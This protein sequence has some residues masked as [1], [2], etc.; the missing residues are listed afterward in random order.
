[1]D[2]VAVAVVGR[3]F[4][5]PGGAGGPDGREEDAK[6]GDGAVHDVDVRALDVVAV[7]EDE[8][9]LRDVEDDWE[10]EV[11]QGDL[12]ERPE[13]RSVRTCG[14]VV[15]GCNGYTER[16]GKK[17]LRERWTRV[18]RMPPALI[19]CELNSGMDRHEEQR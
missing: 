3:G 7:A 10:H 13:T 12:E 8:D 17:T 6:D 14:S 5:E 2:A 9:V 15:S 4:S 19:P 18:A 1:M 11:G 16:S